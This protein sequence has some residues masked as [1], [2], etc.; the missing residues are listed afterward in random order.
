MVLFSF[1]GVADTNLAGESKGPIITAVTGLKPDAV[2]L[3]A[4][5]SENSKH[6][7][8]AGGGSV[9]KVL[10]KLEP[11]SKVTIVTLDIED[12]T[13]HNEI[14]PK[15]KDLLAPYVKSGVD[16]T[17]AI[18]SGTPSMQV[19]WIL[20]GES[21]D[22]PLR[23]I[24]TVEPELS[25]KTI[26]DVTLGTGLPRI[27]ALEEENREL[28]EVALPQIVMKGK[29]GIL[30]IGDRDVK[31]SPTQFAYYRF[32]LELCKK[33]K[34]DDD[35]RLRLSGYDMSDHFTTTVNRFQQEGFPDF[36]AS[37]SVRLKKRSMIA[38]DVFRSN[39]T[40]LN[41]KIISILPSRSLARY[42]QIGHVGS[43]KARHYGIELDPSKITLR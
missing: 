35:R 19:C 29:K 33:G 39:V 13:D 41:A 20:L 12:P 31:L 15:L 16:L 37:D 7:F 6:D 9:K 8:L 17:A 40:K 36:E 24:R 5:Q 23:L 30:T 1:I 38:A 11:R 10:A 27:T 28:R 43:K 32:F 22:V 21:G 42:Y 34:T 2:Y 25:S 26:R 14:Y 18:S 3:I 4:T